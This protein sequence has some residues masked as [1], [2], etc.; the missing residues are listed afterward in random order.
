MV[1][2]DEPE[3]LRLQLYEPTARQQAPAEPMILT[4][5]VKAAAVD[6]QESVPP[7]LPAT[8]ML[9][10]LERHGWVDPHGCPYNWRGIGHTRDH[11]EGV[12]QVEGGL[13]ELH[14]TIA[15]VTD[16]LRSGLNGDQQ[17]F[18]LLRTHDHQFCRHRRPS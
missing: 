17:V 15:V 3:L 12:H 7:S 16:A 1:N 10:S 18:D 11:L 5:P 2:I 6:L 14:E 4:S 8:R 13:T 9:V